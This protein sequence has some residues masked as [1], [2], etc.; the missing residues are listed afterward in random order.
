L[1]QQG[2]VISH[3]QAVFTPESGAYQHGNHDH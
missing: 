3:E 1:L 2:L